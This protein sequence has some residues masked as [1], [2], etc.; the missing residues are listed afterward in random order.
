MHFTCCSVMR[1]RASLIVK[2][3]MCTSAERGSVL[4]VVLDLRVLPQQQT[5]HLLHLMPQQTA[6]RHQGAHQLHTRL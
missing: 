1:T 6:H 4:S 3:R 2:A 5:L